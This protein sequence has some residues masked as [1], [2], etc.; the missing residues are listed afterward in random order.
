MQKERKSE[1]RKERIGAHWFEKVFSWFEKKNLSFASIL[2]LFISS[3]IFIS[4]CANNKKE[5]T[6]SELLSLKDSFEDVKEF[7]LDEK[8]GQ[9]IAKDQILIYIAGKDRADVENKKSKVSQI[10]TARKGEFSILG[11]IEFS[12]EKGGIGVLLQARVPAGT[13]EEIKEIVSEVGF[14]GDGIRAFPNMR[15]KP[16]AIL[17]GYVPLDPLFDSWDETPGGNNWHF[18]AVNMPKLWNLETRGKVPVAVIDF[19]IRKHED[20]EYDLRRGVDGEGADWAQNHGVSVL[21][22]LGAV[23]NNSKGIAGVIWRGDIKAYVIDGALSSLVQSIVL[24]LQ[25]KAKVILFAGGL[26]WGSISPEGNPE[27]EAILEYHREI[28]SVVF[29][30]VRYYDALFVQSAGNEGKD[31]KWAGVGAS[32]KDLFPQNILLVGAVDITGRISTFSNKGKLVDLYLPGESIFTTCL[33]EGESNNYGGYC[34]VR[35]TS[36]SAALGAGVAVLLRSINQD[37]KAGDIKGLI[38]KGVRVEGEGDNASY[39]IDFSISGNLARVAKPSEYEEISEPLPEL[40]PIEDRRGGYLE[41]KSLE[42]AVYDSTYRVPKCPTDVLGCSTYGLVDGNDNAVGYAEPNQPNTLYNSCSDRAGTGTDAGVRIISI[43]VESVAESGFI[44]SGPTSAQQRNIKVTVRAWCNDTNQWI[45]VWYTSN[46][47]SNPPSFTYIGSMRCGC[48]GGRDKCNG[49]ACQGFSNPPVF[50]RFCSTTG[51]PGETTVNFI[52]TLPTVS[53]LPRNMAIRARI[54]N[55]GAQGDLNTAACCTS[56][57]T[58]CS[59]E[60]GNQVP[61]IYDHDDLVFTVQ[62]PSSSFTCGVYNSSFQAPVCYGDGW[63]GTCNLVPCRDTVNDAA[64]SPSGFFRCPGSGTA[65]DPY[66]EP[67]QPNTLFSQCQDGTN[68][69]NGNLEDQIRRINIRSLAPSGKF[70]GGENVEI[71]WLVT[72]DRNSN[73]EMILAYASGVTYSPSPITNWRYITTVQCPEGG[74]DDYWYNMSYVL[75]LDNVEGW[76]AVRVVDGRNPST[77]PVTGDICP[78]SYTHRDADDFIFYVKAKPPSSLPVCA[79]YDDTTEDEDPEYRTPKCPAGASAC[80]TCDLIKS[81]DGLSGTSESGRPN[82][83]FGLCADDGP[84]TPGYLQTESIE[85]IEIRDLSGSGTFQPGLTV[86]VSVL[87]YC[88]PVHPNY[89]ND[90]LVLLYSPDADSP[91]FTRILTAT[92]TTSGYNL[93]IRTPITLANQPGR[94]VIR[95]MFQQGA[96]SAD[97]TCAGGG[98]GQDG[99]TDD[100]VFIVGVPRAP[101]NFKAQGVAPDSITLSWFDV[102]GEDYYELRWTDTYNPD[103]SKWYPH[104]ASPFPANT[105][106]YV[107]QPLPE[108]AYRCYAL[109]ACNGNGCSDFVSDCAT[110]PSLSANCAVYDSTW[111]VPRCDGGVNNCSTCDLVVS[112]D[113]LPRRQEINTPNAW[114][115]SSCVDGSGGD[116]YSSRS[117]E[118]ITLKTTA[119]S[120]SP[121]YQISVTVRVFCSS[122]ADYV[123]LY[124]SAGTSPISWGSPVGSQACS[125]PNRVEDKTFTFEPSADNWYVIRAVVTGPTPSTCPG[126]LYDEVDDVAVRVGGVPPTPSGFNVTFVSPDIARVVWNDVAG[127][128]YYQLVSAPSA[129]GPFTEDTP[130]SPFPANTTQHDHAGLQPGQTLCFQ[131]RACN[132][133]GCSVPTPPRCTMA[134]PV[135]YEEARYCPYSSAPGNIIFS[136]ISAEI[137][138]DYE[139][140]EIFAVNNTGTATRAYLISGSGSTAGQI[141]WSYNVG[142]AVWSVPAVGDIDGNGQPEIVIGVDDGRVMVFGRDGYKAQ[143]S[144]CGRVRAVTLADVDGNGDYE[145][146]AVAKV[147]NR[148]YVLDWNGSGLQVLKRFDLASGS[149]N[150]SYAVWFEGKIYVTGLDGKLYIFNYGTDT[151]TTVNIGVPD[152][153]DTPAIGDV[154]GDETKEVVFGGRDGKVYIR[155]VGTGNHEDSVD[156]SSYVS[157]ATC[158]R[159]SLGDANNNGRDEIYVV[160]TDCGNTGNSYI[161]GIEWNGTSYQVKWVRGPY[162]DINVSHAVIADIN[163]DGYGEV[164]FINHEGKMYIYKHDGNVLFLATLNFGGNGGR[165]GVSLIDVD[166]DGKQNF[167]FGDRSGCIHIYEFGKENSASGTIWWGYNRQNPQQNGVR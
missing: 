43:Q 119:S 66:R 121:G 44:E 69:K 101:S 7:V 94:H 65:A 25:D 20:L 55:S 160:A 135:P 131:L 137:R 150:N 155:S 42:G 77:T 126:G 31:A 106:W 1:R 133:L 123:H 165:G 75:R 156:L 11:E 148:V 23:G 28:F 115:S 34:V 113:S 9:E 107:D 59:S 112:R 105:T 51:R 36:Y 166:E 21:G 152:G 141:I 24:A 138:S 93:L 49:G 62:N 61:T 162:G 136:V 142:Q 48:G 67:N 27:A 163:L 8:T 98:S 157:S 111:K 97:E 33:G 41:P 159:I 120:F 5:K 92:C 139:G 158:F 144:L 45:D 29:Q 60:R 79:T 91:T 35:G 154:D 53:S 37:L 118:K 124:V 99:D 30:Y 46:A 145:I 149:D 13:P 116:W 12:S 100:L 56:S 102:Q 32:V 129:S 117:I 64:E 122:T 19:G 146:I 140:R 57:S 15:M 68:N 109:R 54:Q 88:D 147:C 40:P 50:R 47:D 130:H 81:R 76:H 73:S 38:L 3:F 22:V 78:S 164:I 84:A 14:A 2:L 71:L 104:P 58:D 167:V 85:R 70:E 26:E 4:S 90:Y 52:M 86:E 74:V 16:S 6:A 87:V 108:G 134:D 95:A 82:T 127:E 63:C 10:I 18:E 17:G 151:T 39:V 80:S 96:F 125:Q 143:I 89:L 128:T 161:I 153:L 132:D 72:C 114:Y 110:V 83:L 103:F